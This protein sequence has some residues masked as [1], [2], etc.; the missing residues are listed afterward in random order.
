MG[1]KKE[2][3]VLR[4]CDIVFFPRRNVAIKPFDMNS[5]VRIRIKPVVTIQPLPSGKSSENANFVT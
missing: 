1:R 3:S 4:F 2:I 5:L